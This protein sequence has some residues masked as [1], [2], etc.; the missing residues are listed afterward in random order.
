[1]ADTSIISKEKKPIGK[2]CTNCDTPRD[3]TKFFNDIKKAQIKKV[4][5]K[6]EKKKEFLATHETCPYCGSLRFKKEKKKAY[7]VPNKDKN[8]K[9]I[10]FERF[11][12]CWI[13]TCSNRKCRQKPHKGMWRLGLPM[14]TNF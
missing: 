10:S 14:P 13:F 12:P 11:N 2:I 4:Q 3:P 8:G 5:E 6:E 7:K 9:I 1:M